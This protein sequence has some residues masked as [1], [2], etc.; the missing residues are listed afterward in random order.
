MKKLLSILITM[1]MVLSL[2]C[3]P[4]SATTTFTPATEIFFDDFS[5]APAY[6]ISTKKGDKFCKLHRRKQGDNRIRLLQSVI[7]QGSYNVCQSAT[8]GI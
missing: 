6:T 2:V 8:M 5:V 4:V 3:V 7:N 1:S